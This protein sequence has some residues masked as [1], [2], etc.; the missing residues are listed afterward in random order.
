MHVIVRMVVVAVLVTVLTVSMTLK[1][2]LNQKQKDFGMVDI[3][4]QGIGLLKK[5]SDILGFSTSTPQQ[6]IINMLKDKGYSNNAISGILANIE[7]E[8]G[9]TFDYEQQEDEGPGYGLF[10]FD[11]GGMMPYYNKYLEENDLT[12]SMQSQIDFM[13]NV[14]KGQITYFDGERDAPILGGGN[15]KKLQESFKKENSSEIAKD[16][17][18]IFEKGKMETDYGNRGDLAIKIDEEYF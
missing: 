13:D 9:G 18:T 2:K 5:I 14:S 17:N 12:D 15:V 1:L 10:Q 4:D 11:P 6:E 3:K 8:T 7:L 16:F